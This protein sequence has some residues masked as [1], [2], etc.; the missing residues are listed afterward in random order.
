MERDTPTKVPASPAAAAKG[1][2]KGKSSRPCYD[3]MLGK[4]SRGESCQYSHARPS[5]VGKDAVE[6]E[7]KIL[8][9]KRSTLPCAAFA[10][11]RCK[12]GKD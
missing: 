12:F 8:A 6:R 4:C 3:W 10:A 5:G 11:G 1:Q 7:K 9:E 2:G